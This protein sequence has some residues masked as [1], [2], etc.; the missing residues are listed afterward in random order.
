MGLIRNI[1][2]FFG[3][4]NK[5]KKYAINKSLF[6]EKLEIDDLDKNFNIEKYDLDNKVNELIDNWKENNSDDD[7]NDIRNLV[8]KI[9]C[10][11]ELRYPDCNIEDNDSLFD[12]EIVSNLALD[13]KNFYNS[14]TGTEQ[15]YLDFPRYKEIIYVHGAHFH[16]D[17]NGFIIEGENLQSMFEA[18]KCPRLGNLNVKHA[19]K[20][21]KKRGFEEYKV[22]KQLGALAY[23][24]IMKKAKDNNWTQKEFNSYLI[25]HRSVFNCIEI[26]SENGIS[27]DAIKKLRMLE[28]NVHQQIIDKHNKMVF[29]YSMLNY[30]IYYNDTHFNGM[31]IKDVYNILK[32]DSINEVLL[33]GLRKAVEDYDYYMN[34]R[35]QIL[36]CAMYR[37][38]D[39]GGNNGCR[40]ALLF[41][42]EFDRNIDIPMMYGYYWTD[43]Y[44]KEFVNDYLRLGG[45]LDLKCLSDD[46]FVT[47]REILEWENRYTKEETSLHQKLV[48]TLAKQIDPVLLEQE[49]VNKLRIERKLN[50][51]S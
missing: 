18:N 14:L 42:K 45:K 16:L 8:E 32:R 12:E 40:R 25:N 50:R 44:L 35:N 24:Y 9:A 49:K 20:I 22:F 3:R 51:K 31:H 10:W 13:Y 38:I 11:Y 4:K 28:T 5:D 39:R 15:F 21:L 27:M 36:D 41:A 7:V 1:R 47:V 29:R 23:D 26:L 33:V 17:E 43:P 6:K 48:D 34:F 2:S 46:D 19:A 37:I 30:Y